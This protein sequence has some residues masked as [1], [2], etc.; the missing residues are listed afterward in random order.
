MNP[1]G[2]SVPLNNNNQ[3]ESFQTQIV[4]PTHRT[5]IDDPWAKRDA[6][7]GSV[8]PK[9]SD[10]SPNTTW[11]QLAQ[12]AMQHVSSSKQV[13]YFD[14]PV[15]SERSK[16]PK[17]VESYPKQSFDDTSPFVY[18]AGISHQ[19]L[20][21]LIQSAG[22]AYYTA[23][24]AA[25]VEAIQP[26][27]VP[28][29]LETSLLGSPA[30]PMNVPMILLPDNFVVASVH[31]TDYLHI[32]EV[33]EDFCRWM[34]ATFVRIPHTF[35]YQCTSSSQRSDV[36]FNINLYTDP[37]SHHT[38]IEFQR[39]SGSCFGFS[40]VFRAARYYLNTTDFVE[41]GVPIADSTRNT[42]AEFKLSTSD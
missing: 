20:D 31:T 4:P 15:V 26:M 7:W 2:A 18:S 1:H 30:L 3:S 25:D 38:I 32:R 28:G 9:K 27:N 42:F 24:T 29:Q 36:S 10:S 19:H 8:K 21:E 5:T 17:P 40:D 16:Q 22:T 13:D 33:L 23:P 35:S 6:L 14:D 37:V 12:H 41:G 34:R 11:K 39:W